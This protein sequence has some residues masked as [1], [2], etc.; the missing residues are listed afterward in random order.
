MNQVDTA[1]LFANWHKAG[2]PSEGGLAGLS[3]SELLAINSAEVSGTAVPGDSMPALDD[4]ARHRALA[5]PSYLATEIVDEYYKQ[6]FE[7]IHYQCMDDV[8]APYLLG[9]MLTLEDCQYDPKMYLGLIMLFSRDTWK[10]SMMWMMALWT[11]LYKKC[12]ENFD[13][14]AMYVHQV[15]KKAVKRGENIR[16]T[17]RHSSKFRRAFPE[18]AAP[19]G[20]WDTKEEWRW[21]NFGARG[22]GEWSFTCYGETSEK[23][24]GH[25]THRFIDD[26]ETNE[27]KSVDS[28]LDNYER[29]KAMDPL[30]DRTVGYCPQLIAG[31]TYFFDG[32]HERLLRDGGYMVWKVPA[33]RGSPKVLFDMCSL[34]P[35]K[36]AEQKRIENTIKKLEKERADDLNFPQ[37]LPWRELYLC[38]RAQGPR[39][40]NGQMLVNP[41]PEGETRFSPDAL[42]EIWC[43]QIP[44][45]DEMWIYIRCDPAISKKKEACETAYVVGGVTWS[46]WRFALDGWMGR[47]NQPNRIVR[48][49]FDLARYW[50]DE[51]YTVKQIGYEAVAYQEALAQIARYGVPERE[52]VEHNESIPVLMRPCPIVS[53]PRHTD[54]SQDERI[55]SMD[56]PISR[57]EL[58]IWKRCR[59]GDKLEQQLRQFPFGKRDGIDAMQGLWEKTSVPPKPLIID[60][61]NLPRHM[62][63]LMA[64]IKDERPD[65]PKFTGGANTVSLATW[66]S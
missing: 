56:G 32:C 4:I 51:G 58:K 35:R 22:A 54:V 66:G 45:P 26:W 14:R 42:D 60:T 53:M 49:G 29:F 65:T 62:L 27:L 44:G 18:F 5:Q 43:D 47:E 17:A 6:N 11:Y 39:I 10:S 33:H 19:K 37:R 24:G 38:S 46:G 41:V 59:I 28:R 16:D 8:M 48:K 20:E 61:P 7:P 30:K 34:D 57:R 25:Y 36:P 40:Y 21:P 3:D 64:K 2:N 23:T 63:E 31:T 1:K 50:Q 55:L 9:E 15:L 52:A 12:N 13:V